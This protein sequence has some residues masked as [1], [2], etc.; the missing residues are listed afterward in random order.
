M[1]FPCP[2]T[3]TFFSVS[4]SSYLS[5]AKAPTTKETPSLASQ[6]KTKTKPKPDEPKKKELKPDQY[7]AKDKRN[8]FIWEVV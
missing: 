1:F 2:P 3:A 4:I 7:K 5:K 6:E 8:N